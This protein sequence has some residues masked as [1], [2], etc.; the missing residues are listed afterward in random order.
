MESQHTATG[1]TGI[2]PLFRQQVIDTLCAVLKRI[3][4]FDGQV[5]AEMDLREDLGLKSEPA[6]EML[7][8]VEEQL[9]IQVDTEFLDVDEMRTVADL[10]TF[11]AGHYRAA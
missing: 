2:D 3:V 10:G 11:I 9:G 6:L 5:T 8:D 4:E 7:L 1:Q